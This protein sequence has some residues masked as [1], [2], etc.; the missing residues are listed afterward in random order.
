MSHSAEEVAREVA[1]RLLG[2]IPED[3]KNWWEGWASLNDR[4][5]LCLARSPGEGYSVLCTR[6]KDHIGCHVATDSSSRFSA[7]WPQR[8]ETSE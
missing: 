3:A 1:D 6:P 7:R 4:K 8:K 5:D 2:R